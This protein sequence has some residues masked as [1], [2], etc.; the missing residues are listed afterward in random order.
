MFAKSD[1]IMAAHREKLESRGEK[2]ATSGVKV[3]APTIR[4]NFEYNVQFDTFSHLTGRLIWIYSKARI[5]AKYKVIIPPGKWW[6]KQLS[7]EYICVFSFRS[8]I[9]GFSCSLC[10][11]R[12]SKHRRHRNDFSIASAYRIVTMCIFSA[13]AANEVILLH[14]DFIICSN[15]ANAFR[16]SGQTIRGFGIL[17]S[18]GRRHI[19]ISPP[20]SHFG[21]IPTKI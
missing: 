16:M 20:L 12:H 3:K 14:F 1:I 9:F 7:S 6:S 8:P 13:K 10:S 19:Q 15:F 4:K 5:F 17:L 2:T 21:A 11:S 18:N